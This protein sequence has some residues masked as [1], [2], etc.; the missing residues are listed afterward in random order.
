MLNIQ[1]IENRG[2]KL[3]Q[4][5]NW[6]NRLQFTTKKPSFSGIQTATE[7]VDVLTA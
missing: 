2:I 1:T 3:A 5:S 7:I 6:K 4:A